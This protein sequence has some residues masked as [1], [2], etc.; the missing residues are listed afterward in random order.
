MSCALQ[1]VLGSR[2]VFSASAATGAL[3]SVREIRLGLTDR[4][5]PGG[6]HLDHLTELRSTPHHHCE[7]SGSFVFK[8]CGPARTLFSTTLRDQ[9]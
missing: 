2:A 5:A 3:L 6:L 8:T 4:K 1:D 9:N 7:Q